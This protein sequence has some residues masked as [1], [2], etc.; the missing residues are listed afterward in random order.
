MGHV[1]D[2][3]GLPALPSFRRPPVT[4]VVLSI[5]FDPL[6]GLRAVD[7]FEFYHLKYGETFPSVDEKAPYVIPVE[8]FGV[9]SRVPD[10]KFELLDQPMPIRHWFIS[11]D[12][13]ELVQLQSDWFAR[14][15]RKRGDDSTYPRYP[16]IREPFEKDLE[17]FQDFLK[18]RG[19]GNLVPTQC[20]VSYFNQVPSDGV[21]RDH[22]EL[23]KVVRYWQSSPGTHFSPS[24][25]QVQFAASYVIPGETGPAGRL[26]VNLSPAWT[27]DL[28]EPIFAL[29]LTARGPAVGEGISGAMAFL[30]LGHDWIVRCFADVT[31]DEMHALWGL[32]S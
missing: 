9:R 32:E 26:H 25:E 23:S 18:D 22:G 28:N 8:R 4:E 16:S 20:E 14:N 19:I 6:P 3:Q 10:V 21:W 31:T 7:I 13:S 29:N 30:D 17:D 2:D 1:H 27:V 12:G 11:D 15:W 5:G 24:P